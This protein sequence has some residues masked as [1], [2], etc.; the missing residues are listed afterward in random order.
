MDS[1][2]EVK[3]A[4]SGVGRERD[5][6][7]TMESR[8]HAEELGEQLRR[9]RLL[10]IQAR[11]APYRRTAFAVLALAL[12]AAGPW[13]GWWWLIPLGCAAAA[14]AFTDWLLPR[15]AHPERVAAA[16]WAIAP[17]MIAVSVALTGAATSPA[18]AWFALPAITLVTRFEHTGVWI[19]AAY[20]GALLLGSTFALEPAVVLDDPTYL[21]FTFALIAGAM[22]FAAAVIDS[23][24]DHRNST[25][26]DPLT[27]LLNRAAL[28]QHVADLRSAPNSITPGR[29]G[30]LI[31]DLDHF[32]RINDEHGHAT[33]DAVLCDVAYAIRGALRSLDSAYRL[34]GE[35]FLI[36]LPDA[37]VEG[38]LNVGERLRAAVRECSRPEVAVSISLGGAVDDVE[39]LDFSALSA[40][41]DAALYEAKHAGRDRVRVRTAADPAPAAAGPRPGYA[42]ELQP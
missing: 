3:G 9:E 39:G 28:A 31:A 32:K 1:V 15:S 23:D 38:V 17:L 10:D 18:L 2:R 8:P 29:L 7:L 5:L 22:A 14:F 37:S 20:I 34:G 4:T 41:A 12:V 40:R 33:G 13:Q 19:G 42:L 24:R 11:I 30:L 25:L 36:L 35:E 6:T 21:I 27:G 26:F 16:G